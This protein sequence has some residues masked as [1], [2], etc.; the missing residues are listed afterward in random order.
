M[1]RV[2][3]CAEI[4]YR[5][6]TASPIATATA[7]LASECF[8]TLPTDTL[9][10]QF[11]DGR[12]VGESNYRIRLSTPMWLGS[13]TSIA[14]GALE[15]ANDDGGL[16]D[17]V[18]LEFR[19][20]AL[21]L[22]LHTLGTSYD[23]ATVL[24]N[25]S[26]ERVE[27]IDETRMRI[28]LRD[29]AADLNKPLATAVYDN[30]TDAEG[31]LKPLAF[32]IPKLCAPVLVSE[33]DLEY[34]IHANEVLGIDKVYDQGVQ[35]DYL[36]VTKGFQLTANPAGKVTCNP[37]TTGTG[38]DP[39]L[40]SSPTEYQ[41]SG[42]GRTLEMFE[43]GL[44]PEQSLDYGFADIALS[45]SS[46]AGG[47]FYFEMRIEDL[48]TFTSTTTEI[49]WGPGSRGMVGIGIASAA[50]VQPQ[51]SLDDDFYIFT[52]GHS[53]SSQTSNSR[54]HYYS[55][56]IEPV[57][58]AQINFDS[59][60]GDVIGVKVNF[61][62]SPMTIEFL[63]NGTNFDAV[64]GPHQIPAGTYFP[65]L[66]AN[67][68]DYDN[69]ATIRVI[70]DDFSQ[71]IPSGY[72]AWAGGIT[73]DS[74]FDKLTQS[75][76]TLLPSISFDATSVATLNALA[77]S[78]P[79]VTYTYGYYLREPTTAAQVLE[80]A[81]GSIGGYYFVNRLGKVQ[82]GQL[83]L[84]GSSV[85]T[86]TDVQING[87]ISI[88]PD[89]APGLTDGI[90]SNRNHEP[91][92]ES[93]VAGSV[94]EIFKQQITRRYQQEYR[95]STGFADA[96]EDAVGAALQDTLLIDETAASTEM[97]RIAALFAGE[98]KFYTV[99]IALN[100]VDF[101]EILDEIGDT[102]TLDYDRFGLDAGLDLVLVGVEG[103]FLDNELRLTLWGGGV[104]AGAP[105]VSTITV[106]NSAGTEFEISLTVKNS[107][108][109]AFEIPA[110]VKNSAGTE[111][112]LE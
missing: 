34:H 87:D 49:L 97:E 37:V 43:D 9:A 29:P 46:V 38:D 19:R 20:R 95:S 16:D 17:W 58:A 50:V 14:L 86:L 96:Y 89:H 102:Y 11:F 82:V 106:K 70:A 88:E 90:G 5:N 111:F 84:A 13:G 69:I 73:A 12:L 60:I 64:C 33:N 47:K 94:T 40:T 42:Q 105:V 104:D 53:F 56:N 78:S 109:T 51:D 18:D 71:S 10:N 32:G 100:S 92:R 66:G 72:S 31:V 52:A 103:A 68:K 22:K 55:D 48:K 57:A 6:V 65:V 54:W 7:Y 112:A 61:D 26:M 91:Y 75:I 77:H 24:L 3:L 23:N 30:T 74:D 44:S 101:D 93:E 80:A 99:P 85:R 98:R 28:L 27:P 36:P 76:T 81:L 79:A 108:G 1:S 67:R 39:A 4:S 15:V 25:A 35:V 21:V 83:K 41:L 8:V 63:K 107:A 2:V 110:T 59:A 62:A 45:K